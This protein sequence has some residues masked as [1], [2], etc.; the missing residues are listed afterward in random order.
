MSCRNSIYIYLYIGNQL[1]NKY[2]VGSYFLSF[3]R[4]TLLSI[5][6]LLFCA[7]FFLLGSFI[8]L[9]LLYFLFFCPGYHCQTE[10]IKK[11]MG[12]STYYIA[13]LN[14]HHIHFLF[15]SNMHITIWLYQFYI[16]KHIVHGL[17]PVSL[18]LSSY[19]YMRVYKMEF[20]MLSHSI[21]NMQLL[22]FIVIY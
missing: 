5:D 10:E 15:Y 17:S 8:W 2:M 1:L 21:N 3:H 9:L 22:F 20:F 12:C 18:Y 16:T 13:K 19:I 14:V 7:D 11:Q 6:Y 4:Y